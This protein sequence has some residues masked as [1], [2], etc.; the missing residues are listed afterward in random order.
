VAYDC[1]L[2]PAE[3]SKAKPM[4][5]S[6]NAFSGADLIDRMSPPESD[7]SLQDM[8]APESTCFGCGPRNPK[9]L[10]IKSRPLDGEVVADWRPEPHHCAFAGFASGGIIS[11]LLDCH[12][13]WAAAY[14][15]MKSRGLTKPPGT[16]TAEYT[17][18]FLRPTPLNTGWHLRARASSVEGDR[19]RVEG[20]LEVDARETASM[21]GLFVAVKADHPAFHRWE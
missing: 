15:L 4:A 12:G 18:R 21:S 14:A 17:V 3:P 6:W 10:H 13:N 1:G 19:V 7:A 16:V 20:H 2:L 5:V 8:F 11:V 9:G